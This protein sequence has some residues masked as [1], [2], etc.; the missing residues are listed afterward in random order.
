MPVVVGVLIALIFLVSF[1]EWFYNLV[2]GMKQLVL[3]DEFFGWRV[4]WTSFVSMIFMAAV[5]FG[6][7][8]LDNGQ[9]TSLKN[10]VFEQVFLRQP[11]S[12]H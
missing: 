9:L 4:A 7:L 5:F 10:T 11:L 1:S 6:L 8:A 3:D 2:T 12:T